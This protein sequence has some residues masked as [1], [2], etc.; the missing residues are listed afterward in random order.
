MN[1]RPICAPPNG[2]AP[3]DNSQVLAGVGPAPCPLEPLVEPAHDGSAHDGSAYND[4]AAAN[5]NTPNPHTQR[6][7]ASDWAHFTAWCRRQ[8][9]N[10]LPPSPQLVGLYI[11][12]CASGD[13]SVGGK[14]NAR[15]TLERRLSALIHAYAQRGYRLDR[16]HP[17][18][19]TLRAA[20]RNTPSAPPR[21]KAAI[22]REDLIAMLETLERGTLRGLRDRAMLLIGFA[23]NLRRSQIVGLDCGPEQTQ[24]GHGWVEIADHAIVLT[25]RAQNRW[26]ELEIPTSPSPA[27]CP[28]VALRTW[29]RLAHIDHGPLFRRVRAQG[30]EVGTQRLDA[31]EIA[32]LV[33]R[34]ALAA[35]V[36]GDL[37]ERERRE[38]FAG[39]SLRT[40]PTR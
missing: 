13:L 22:R 8:D 28:V 7:Y 21:Q 5:P 3:Q 19:T 10:L 29:L 26:R 35:G 40:G 30:K 17:H 25:L 36:R 4:V 23:G 12:A 32:R 37:S 27:T 24:D 1:D 6:A 9:L 33:K 14:S 15:S 31:R 20:I 16:R 34:T 18:L 38:S 2:E 39:N 11:N